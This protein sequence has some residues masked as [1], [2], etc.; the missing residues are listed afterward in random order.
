M[1]VLTYLHAT[2]SIRKNDRNSS[3][4]FDVGGINNYQEVDFWQEALSRIPAPL[5]DGNKIKIFLV[6]RTWSRC[7]YHNLLL[8]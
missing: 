5:A 6:L 3:L 7:D 4:D 1:S 8:K 2:Y